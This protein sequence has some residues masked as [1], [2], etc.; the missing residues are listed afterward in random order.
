MPDSPEI[1]SGSDSREWLPGVVGC[2]SSNNGGKSTSIR[3]GDLSVLF[4][5][6]QFG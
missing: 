2:V 4:V 6:G 3:Q 5:G 1:R